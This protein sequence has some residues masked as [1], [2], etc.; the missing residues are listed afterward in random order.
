MTQHIESRCLHAKYPRL[1]AA[2]LHYLVVDDYRSHK[3]QNRPEKD[4]QGTDNYE[5]Y[6]DFGFI[7]CHVCLLTADRR[8]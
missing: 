6:S 1:R 5:T 8:C 3:R 4:G 7:D 2:Y